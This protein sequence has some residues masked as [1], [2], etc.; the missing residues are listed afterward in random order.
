MR[1]PVSSLPYRVFRNQT[2]LK[3]RNVCQVED[4]NLVVQDSSRKNIDAQFIEIDNV[5]INLRNK[6]TKAYGITSPI[7]VPKYWL[8]FQVTVPPLGWNTYFVSKHNS[9]GGSINHSLNSRKSTHHHHIH[10]HHHH[11]HVGKSVNSAS[12]SGQNDTIEIG[13]GHI[14]MV[15]S[16]SSGRLLR[17]YNK[18][19]GVDLSIDQSILY[20]NSST[21]DSES[22]QVYIY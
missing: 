16:A 22:Y 18:V 3:I 1:V 17:M 6:Y 13:P 9:K 8:V 14:K 10:R 15:F 21:G 7:R 5:T 11:H 20:Y 19:T 12:R 2:E 4:A